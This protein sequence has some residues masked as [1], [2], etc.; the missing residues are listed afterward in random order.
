M[1][2]T[3]LRLGISHPLL[4][5]VKIYFLNMSTDSPKLK[6]RSKLFPRFFL[7]P[8]KQRE[9]TRFPTGTV[10]LKICFPQYKGRREGDRKLWI[11]LIYP[12]CTRQKYS[13]SVCTRKK[14]LP[15]P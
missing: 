1:F 10:F 15:K 3:I 8:Y 9:V 4:H 5:K 7:L 14:S 2:L 12:V 13:V 11:S 6:S